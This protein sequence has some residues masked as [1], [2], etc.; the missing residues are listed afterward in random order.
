MARTIEK[1]AVRSWAFEHEGSIPSRST[2][3]GENLSP[4]LEWDRGPEGTRSYA[5]V[6][7]DPDAP[8]GL[9]THWVAWNL[10]APSLAE[11]IPAR[12]GGDSD[13]RQGRN[14]W[15]KAGY[16]GPCP[17]SGTHRYFF[18]VWALDRDLELPES[19]DADALR[20]AIR[21]HVLAEGVLMGRY[22]R[23]R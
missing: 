7:D 20:A 1:L 21:G 22:A 10:R 11:G 3:D 8:G 13:L 17:P 2:C 18:H 9:F 12:G 6:C 4:P 23:E 5:L 15:D 16:A 14:S 19:T